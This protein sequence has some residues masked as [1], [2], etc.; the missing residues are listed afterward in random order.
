[1][2]TKYLFVYYVK[3]SLDEQAPERTMKSLLPQSC[4]DTKLL[5][6]ETSVIKLIVHATHSAKLG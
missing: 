3:F 2:Y 5:W 4:Y 1:M 6:Y